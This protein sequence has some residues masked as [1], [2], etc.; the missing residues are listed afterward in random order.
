MR[1]LD[2]GCGRAKEPGAVGLDWNPATDADVVADV[3]ALPVLPGSFDRIL[4]RHII[5]HVED[6]IRFLEEIHGAAREGAEVEGITPHFSNPC[7]FA[8]PTHRHHFSLMFL[9]FFLDGRD[10]P[11]AAAAAA[12]WR[13]WANRFLECYYPV[14][15]FYTGARFDL[16]ERRITFCRLHRWLGIAWLANRFPEIWEFHF[17]GLFRARDICFRLR[18]KK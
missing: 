2:I 18:V 13:R 9:D 8:D 16:I 12:G 4:I 5:E 11:A 14:I 15:S 3:S 10:G 1:I 17:S 6:P 7:S